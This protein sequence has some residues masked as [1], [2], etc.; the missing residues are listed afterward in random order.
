MANVEDMGG[1]FILLVPAGGWLQGRGALSSFTRIDFSRWLV[2]AM[3]ET[4]SQV[5]QIAV[6]SWPQT[7]QIDSVPLHMMAVLMGVCVKC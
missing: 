6:I 3:N 1:L 7:V 5:S 2:S 4:K